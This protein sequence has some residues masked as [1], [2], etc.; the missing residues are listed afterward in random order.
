MVR[1][2]RYLPESWLSMKVALTAWLEGVTSFPVAWR[3]QDAPSPAKPYASIGALSL[4]VVEG[5]A[6]TVNRFAARILSAEPLTLY[7]VL[8]EIADTPIAIEYLSS[9]TPT[10][11]EIQ[12]GLIDQTVAAFGPASAFAIGADAVGFDYTDEGELVGDGTVSA[13]LERNLAECKVSDGI[14]TFQ[15]DVYGDETVAGGVDAATMAALRLERSLEQSTV[16]EA[17]SL[18]GWAFLH[19]TAVRRIPTIRNGLVEVRPGFDIR[20]RS[21][22]RVVELIDYIDGWDASY[23][24]GSVNH[25]LA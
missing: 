23:A 3:D 25:G 5:Q 24:S 12:A 14:S 20:L 8:V 9:T 4:G 10:V 6:Y 16:R 7:S 11:A 15:V 13:E 17:L 1:P 2:V 18:G 19:S 22:M 21:R